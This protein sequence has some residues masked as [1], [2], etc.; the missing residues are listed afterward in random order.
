MEANNTFS[1]L[2]F[3]TLIVLFSVS[4]TACAPAEKTQKVI[5][6]TIG[7]DTTW[8][9]DTTYILEGKVQVINGATLTIEPGTLIKANPGEYPN[10]S[11]LIISKGS[12]IHAVGTAERP[13][14][15]TS[16]DDN[17]SSVSESGKTLLTENNKGLWGGIIILG[18]AP[19]SLDSGESETFYLGLNPSDPNNFYG[20]NQADDNSGKLKYVS[21]RFGGTYM[22]TGSESNGLTLSGVGN[23]T[24]IDQIEVYANQDDGIEFFGGTVNASN[25]M[26]FSSG[27]DGI[28]LDEGYSGNL[29][30]VMVVL[31]EQSDSGMEISGGNGSFQ[32][33]F[34][35]SDVKLTVHTATEDQQIMRLDANAQGKIKGLLASNFLDVSK[36]ALASKA[37][38]IEQLQIMKNEKMVNNMDE[39]TGGATA[40]Q[41]KFS[42]TVKTENGQNFDWTLAQ[43]KVSH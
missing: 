19:V 17:I 15:F 22:G 4:I 1:S 39:I 10:A 35:I 34:T 28:D 42:D 40:D 27:D 13:I 37:V 29:N 7:K 3:G 6:G 16:L 26:V 31:G 24:E 23:Q 21:I 41:I 18:N 32:G 11:M 12:K 9:A 25:L 33:N 5:Q 20:G 8:T 36:V 14:I 30:N 2:F 43:Q 38:T